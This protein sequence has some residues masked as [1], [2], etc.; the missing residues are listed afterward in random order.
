[1]AKLLNLAIKTKLVL[2]IL[3]DF[4]TKDIVLMLKVYLSEIECKMSVNES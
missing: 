2:L 1:M 3:S 4:E